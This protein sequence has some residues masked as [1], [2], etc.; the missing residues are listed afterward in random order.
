MIL[1]AVS[2]GRSLAPTQ[3]GISQIF[4]KM[5]TMVMDARDPVTFGQIQRLAADVEDINLSIQ[6]SDFAGPRKL[7]NTGK[8]EKFLGSMKRLESL[9]CS[10]IK[11]NHSPLP[12]PTLSNIFGNKTWKHLRRLELC[13]FYTF[14]SNLSK[15][16]SRHKS[17]VKEL[18]LQHILLRRGSWHDVFVK[19]RG[20][21]IE[22]VKV[23][24][25][26]FKD[27]PHTFFEDVQEHDLSPIPSSHPLYAFLFQ[28][29]SWSSSIDLIEGLE[30]DPWEDDEE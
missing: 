6:T 9:A 18:A 30:Y 20:S 17:T 10:T 11:L 3:I 27:S 24:H 4:Y 13:R 19:L 8:C 29:A 26:G 14:A 22:T 16:L 12:Y 28:G 15:L 23:H 5:D 2:Q 21:T 7:F 1:T 25:L